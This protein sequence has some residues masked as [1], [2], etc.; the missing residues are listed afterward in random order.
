VH[1]A[2]AL[3]VDVFGPGGVARIVRAEIAGRSLPKANDGGV[4]LTMLRRGKEKKDDVWARAGRDR[5]A[6]RAFVDH[7]V[8]SGAGVTD[9]RRHESLV[10]VAWPDDEA[11]LE[12]CEFAPMS[13]DE[14]VVWLR[15]LVR[16]LLGAPHAYFLPCEAVFARHYVEPDGP[17]VRWLELARDKLRDR[18]GPLALR[19]AYGPVPRPQ[20][21]PVPDEANARAMIES[22]FGAFFAKRGETSR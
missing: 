9:G 10:V 6:L 20:E 22:R 21:Y 14:A 12:R 5:A 11:I 13:R 7:A 1:A 19:S 4:S 2:L 17:A 16:E 15:G 3:D 18:D 8:L